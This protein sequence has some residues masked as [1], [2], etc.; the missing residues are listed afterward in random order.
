MYPFF[1]DPSMVLLIPAII[2][3][4]WAQNKVK[5]TYRYYKREASNS[6][7][8]GAEV[9]RKILDQQGLN[10]VKVVSTKGE[11]SDHYDPRKKTIRLSETNY[12]GSSVSSLGVAAHEV[13]HAAQH[14]EGYLA[15]KFR[16]VLLLPANFGSTL[17][18]PIFIA[19]FIFSSVNFLMDIGIYLFL[20]AL[21]FQL[22]TLPVEFDASKRA[23]ATLR[24]SGIMAE[25]EIAGAR[26]V[27]NAAALT[28]VAAATMAL[29][30]LLR[31]IVL[32]G[33]RD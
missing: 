2:L 31:L 19:G 24:S 32:R 10:N 3:A 1:F 9:A 16:H 33:A 5:S 6:G 8:S 15:L 11:L 20:G 30:H 17:A 4:F 7:L 29:A 22:I 25:S 27:L 12:H 28:Y 26:K 18:F 23:L 13:G 14:A 21:A